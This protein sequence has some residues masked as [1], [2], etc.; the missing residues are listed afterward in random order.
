MKEFAIRKKSK[1]SEL[2]IKNHI[3]IHD[4]INSDHSERV[5]SSAVEIHSK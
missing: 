3:L 5:I 1:E 4:G 2:A